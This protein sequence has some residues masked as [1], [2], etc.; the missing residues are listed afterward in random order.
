M[1]C[2]YRFGGGIYP[3]M[4]SE[5]ATTRGMEAMENKVVLAINPELSAQSPPNLAENSMTEIAV[6]QLADKSSAVCTVLSRGRRKR[7]G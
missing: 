7:R 4:N 3:H 2:Q 1:V 6:G 5:K